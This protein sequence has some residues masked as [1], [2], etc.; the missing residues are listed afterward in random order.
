MALNLLANN[1]K[2]SFFRSIFVISIFVLVIFQL[3][4]LAVIMHLF[5]VHEKAMIGEAE[6]LQ[7]KHLQ[8][9]FVYNREF[10]NNLHINDPV[11]EELIR[12][13]NNFNNFN[14]IPF[15]IPRIT[16]R[17]VIQIERQKII[18]QPETRKTPGLTALSIQNYRNA[19]SSFR[20]KL[21]I[22]LSAT[23]ILSSLA[24][25]F[26]I[27]SIMKPL[28]KISNA[29]SDLA[30]GN[31]SS[32]LDEPKMREFIKLSKSYNEIVK[33]YELVS[34]LNEL[35]EKMDKLS[36]VGHFTTEMEHEINNPLN[37]LTLSMN[38][39]L[40][41]LTSDDPIKQENYSK[42]SSKISEEVEK[43]NKTLKNKL[44]SI[45]RSEKKEFLS[46]DQIILNIINVMKIEFKN[47]PIRVLVDTEP[48]KI[49]A[50]REAMK[51]VFYRILGN[52][53]EESHEGQMIKIS[54][55]K[56]DKSNQCIIAFE[57]I[58]SSMHMSS[59]DRIFDYFYK[60]KEH[61]SSLSLSLIH[62]IIVTEHGGKINVNEHNN[63]F[64]KITIYLPVE[65]HGTEDTCC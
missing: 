49:M 57:I 60:T 24:F 25:A 43:L 22:V 61:S 53:F 9:R 39:L 21:M 56:E 11:F 14:E 8:L 55:G 35:K 36:M 51:V 12:V 16:E 31:F 41:N 33:N 54:I 50:K 17:P 28:E 62:S 64:D 52:L 26:M 20:N 45:T 7:E 18:S 30:D 1:V 58:N 65:E 46:I 15:F 2:L 38:I 3:L 10:S 4:V 48:I 27:I 13:T 37:T 32:R 29:M 6:K 19:L 44:P 63:V 40:D 34:K 5:S 42:F 23:F 59:L 47:K